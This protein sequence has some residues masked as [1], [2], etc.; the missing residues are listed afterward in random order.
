L[1]RDGVSNEHLDPMDRIRKLEAHLAKALERI[2]ELEV[3]TQ[4]IP[5]IADRREMKHL[6]ERY[7]ATG[8]SGRKAR[9]AAWRELNRI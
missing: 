3:E 1:E 4:L 9:D 2:L 8:M 6:V 5:E 7:K